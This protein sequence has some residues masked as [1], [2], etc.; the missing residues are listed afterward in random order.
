MKKTVKIISL[1]LCVVALTALF[2]GCAALDDMKANHA[3]LSEDKETISFNGKTYKALPDESNFYC[4][5]TYHHNNSVTVTDSDVPVLLKDMMGYTTQYDES[6]DMFCVY[7]DT[8]VEG[9]SYLYYA[10]TAPVYYCNEKDYDKFIESIESGVLDRVGFEYETCDEDYNYYYVL[11]VASKEV[12]DEIL[13]HITKPEKMTDTAFDE[14]INDYS[15]E[16]LMSSMFKCDADGILAEYLDG[17]DIYRND[18]GDA[19]LINFTTEKAVK[20]TDK[21]TAA[22]K[23]VYFYG[24]YDYTS[25][26]GIIGSDDGEEEIVIGDVNLVKIG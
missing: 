25:S 12:S 5:Y 1:C 20:L 9:Y 24:D 2:A 14:I 4:S 17:Y 15:A 11:D 8:A 16:C 21:T 23:D 3:I 6:K 18:R 10:F 22:L 26:V 13:G 19:Y 7:I